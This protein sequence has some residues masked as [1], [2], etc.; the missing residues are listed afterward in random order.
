MHNTKIIH[1][2]ST[3]IT[4]LYNFISILPT[5]YGLGE[6]SSDCLGECC[7]CHVIYVLRIVVYDIGGG[8]RRRDVSGIIIRS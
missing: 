6:L 7:V 2:D 3:N 4:I 8:I 1:P 5:Q